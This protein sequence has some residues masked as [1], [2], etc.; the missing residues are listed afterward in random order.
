M[1]AILSAVGAGVVALDAGGRVR[2]IN[3][4]AA[5]LLEQEPRAVIDRT[6][7][8][9]VRSD[10]T[11]AA[12]WREVEKQRTRPRRGERDLVLRRG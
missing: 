4:R 10:G 12:F 2:L 9:L 7:D 11:A 6:V 3:D 1:Q 5:D 8:D